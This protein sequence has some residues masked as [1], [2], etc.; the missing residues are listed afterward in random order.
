[1]LLQGASVQQVAGK[2]RGLVA[3][4][5]LN[6]GELLLKEDPFVAY[7]YETHIASNSWHTLLPGDNLLKC[8][9]CKYARSSFSQ[10]LWHVHVNHI[11]V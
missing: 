2:G 11:L 9:A 8:Q 5:D 1:M 10:D 7:L 6:P 4:R 3:D